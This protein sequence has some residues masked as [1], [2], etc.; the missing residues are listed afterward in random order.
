M[1]TGLG[2]T[3]KSARS[4]STHHFGKCANDDVL[5]LPSP[6]GRYRGWQCP[7]PTSDRALNGCK[8][9]KRRTGRSIGLVPDQLHQ[10]PFPSATVEFAIENLF[11]GSKVEL[12]VR[13]GDDDLSTHDLSLEVCITIVFTG[14]IVPITAQGGVR[15]QFFQPPPEVLMK[16]TFVIIDEDGCGDV[17][18]IDE[19]KPF[20]DPALLEA[21]CN[22]IRDVDE[23]DPLGGLKPEFLAVTFHGALGLEEK[24]DFI[25]GAL[26]LVLRRF[27]KDETVVMPSDAV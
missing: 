16:P 19:T 23:S 22:F 2:L 21:G 25:I 13:D 14:L 8:S 18:G 27:S 17:H 11:P 12:T 9:P 3:G 20:T 6:C 26:P 7:N 15:C 10:D 5:D 4:P 24:G 1:L